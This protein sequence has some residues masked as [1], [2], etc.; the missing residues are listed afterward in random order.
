MLISETHATNMNH[1]TIP[2]YKTYHT[3]HPDESAHGGTAIIIKSKIKHHL[4]NPYRTPHIQATSIV[5]EDLMGDLTIS[6]AYCPPKHNNKEIQYTEYFET[7]GKRFIAGGDYNAKHVHWGSRLITTKG[8]ELLKSIEAG[9]LRVVSSGHPTYWP[10][11]LSKTP[12]LIDFCVYRGIPSHCLKAEPSLEMSSDHTPVLLTLWRQV[13]TINQKCKLHNKKTNWSNFRTRIEEILN[14][15]I[16]LRNEDDITTAVEHLNNC[17][18]QAA[19]ES[20]PFTG[21]RDP[22][23]NY[24]QKIRDK[25]IEK[26][27]LRKQ[28]QLTRCPKLKTKLNYTIKQL[29]L[30]L[31]EERNSCIGNYLQNL[32]TTA[33]SEYSLWK[34]TRKLKQPQTVFPPLRRPDGS[35]G[36]EVTQIKQTLLLNT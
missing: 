12:D 1:I 27:K 36:H 8:R 24:S 15:K 10:T 4:A 6:A 16:S 7:L 19:W 2:G 20:T 18:Q 26:R 25:V 33:S 29:K 17:I 11:D 13:T 3:R 5:V 34:A 35:I 23:L 31:D 14:I 30:L 21:M 22:M 9:G 28:W 32:D